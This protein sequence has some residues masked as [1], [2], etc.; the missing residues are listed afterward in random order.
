[1][2]ILR[3]KFTYFVSDIPELDSSERLDRTILR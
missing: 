1:M 3:I 2:Y